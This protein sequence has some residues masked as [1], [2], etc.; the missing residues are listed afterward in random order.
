LYNRALWGSK[1]DLKEDA[2]LI[3]RTNCH[4]RIP[5]LQGRIKK[6]DLHKVFNIQ[7]YGKN[8]KM[9]DNLAYPA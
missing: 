1:L 5:L 3:L 4:H 2:F 9:H 8:E 7:S 6:V